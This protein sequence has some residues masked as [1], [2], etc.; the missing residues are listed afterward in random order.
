MTCVVVVVVPI[1]VLVDYMEYVY[2]G[3]LFC[4]VI[5]AVC[6]QHPFS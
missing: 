6:F 4:L 2:P 1:A 3:K 5:V